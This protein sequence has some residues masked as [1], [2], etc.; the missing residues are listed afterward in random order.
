[1]KELA[2]GEPIA[3]ERPLGARPVIGFP[4]RRSEPGRLH[5]VILVSS[6]GEPCRAR[7]LPSSPGDASGY[8]KGC[9]IRAVLPHG[10]G[11][12]RQLV[13]QRDGSLVVTPQAFELQ[14]P[15]AQPIER[16]RGRALGV[17]QHRPRPVNEE[18]A[19][20]GVAALTDGA[21]VAAGARRVLPRR[22]PK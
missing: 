10:P 1:M 22:E 12:A 9:E 14:R 4:S 18:H 17:P 19:Q 2:H 11:D 7:A 5:R 8:R 21:Q 13:G 15:C 3:W 16:P 20:I 6:H